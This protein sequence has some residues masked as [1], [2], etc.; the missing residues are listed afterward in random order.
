VDGGERVEA[1]GEPPCLD[2]RRILAGLAP[3]RR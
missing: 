2:H 3:A 1:L